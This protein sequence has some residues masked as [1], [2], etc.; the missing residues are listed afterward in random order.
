MTKTMRF[1]LIISMLVMLSMSLYAQAIPIDSLYLGQTPHPYTPKIFNLSTTSGL[2]PVER[3]AVTSDG[4]EIYYG[5]LN[6]WPA[7]NMRIKCYKYLDNRWQGPSVVFEGYVAPG[8]ADNDSIMYMQKD[9][10]NIACTYFSVRNNSGW[11]APVRLFSL[12]EPTHYFQ[13]TKLNNSYL[14]ST[15]E[16]SSDICK[17]INNNSAAQIQSLGKPINTSNTENDFFIARDESYIIFI[18]FDNSS[19][20]DLYISFKK[21]NGNWTNPKK[22]GD[23]INTPNPNWECCPYVTNDNK[24]LFFTRGGNSMSSYYTYWVKIDNVIDSLKHTNFIPYFKNQIRTQ[25][26]QVGRLFNFTLPSETFIDDDGNNTLTYSATLS[27][28][29]PLPSWLNF[30]P[31]ARTFSGTPAEASLLKIKVTTTD[32]SQA[33]ASCEFE[34]SISK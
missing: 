28:G 32:T 7:T 27:D 20:S 21:D 5:E 23:P 33:F 30:N 25:S 15:L 1:L 18:R 4:K 24:Y 26:I 19:A 29:S 14:S 9:Q 2:R 13:K 22:F 8:L 31:V 10:N 6:T 11:S 34:I 3:I 17:L 12:N 16:G